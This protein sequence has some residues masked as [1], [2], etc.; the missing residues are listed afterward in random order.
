M[1]CARTHLVLVPGFGGFDALGQLHYY[2]NLTPVFRTW[3]SAS[4]TRR[5][6]Q[7]HYFDNLPTAGVDTRA[8]LL[9]RFLSKKVARREFDPEAKDK[10]VLVGH[11]TGGLDIRA[12][13]ASLAKEVA[14]RSGERRHDGSRDAAV[15]VEP[16]ELLDLIDGIV[17][18][19]VPNRG[20][21]IADWVHASHAVVDVLV[22]A[23]R[24]G[25][26]AGAR[27]PRLNLLAGSGVALAVRDSIA[28]TN[29]HRDLGPLEQAEARAALSDIQLWL[30]HTSS[31]FLAIEDLRAGGKRNHGDDLD[32]ELGVWNDHE[33]RCRSYATRGTV[34]FTTPPTTGTDTLRSSMSTASVFRGRAGLSCSDPIYRTAY[35]LTSAGPFRGRADLET[36]TD[37]L[38]GEG[39]TVQPW[40]NDG[41]VN[42]ASMF[43]PNGSSTQLISGDHA[44]IIG[45]FA[46]MLAMGHTEPREAAET[47][48]TAPPAG[49]LHYAYD[50]FVSG[51]GFDA[52]RF[53]AVWT[54]LFAFAVGEPVRNGQPV[55]PA[56]SR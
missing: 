34:P 28:E 52:D 49:R 16:S 30:G 35:W 43:W 22:K 5:G 50:L 9:R 21:N 29:P 6:L 20:T 45:H 18:L 31:D 42:T 15:S 41:I 19:S 44:D 46:D 26:S 56:R 47:P 33:I 2:A 40:E 23:L 8:R 36:A 11:S 48:R 24:L 39:V 4:A 32:D 14:G 12:M 7:L 13:I 37:F 38:T 10:I 25:V 55:A 3:R 54:D 17:F 27:V 53:A 1:S 51:S